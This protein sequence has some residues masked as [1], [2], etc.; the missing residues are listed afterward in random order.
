[1]RIMLITLPINQVSPQKPK[2]RGIKST[3][4]INVAGDDF[5]DELCSTL[6]PR[7]TALMADSDNGDA[8]EG[9]EDEISNI[10]SGRTGPDFGIFYRESKF[11]EK[12]SFLTHWDVDGNGRGWP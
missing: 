2:P 8:S 7:R 9:G 6:V 3:L 10:R 11:E 5:T 4:G 1:M 12:K